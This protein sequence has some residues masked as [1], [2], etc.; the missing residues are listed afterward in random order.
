MMRTHRSDLLS[1]NPQKL[2]TVLHFFLSLQEWRCLGFGDHSSSFSVVRK[3]SSSHQSDIGGQKIWFTLVLV[4]QQKHH[5]LL[6]CC[7]GLDFVLE[8][9]VSEPGSP[10]FQTML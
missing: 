3:S 8:C 1:V 5:Q 2:W 6:L 10:F 4:G 9:F 7:V